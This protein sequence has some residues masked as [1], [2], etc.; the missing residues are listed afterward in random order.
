VRYVLIDT[1]CW[2]D[3][4]V[5]ETE[6]RNL[7][8]LEQWAQEKKII[9][10]VPE[11]LKEEWERNKNR[12]LNEIRKGLNVG[13]KGFRRKAQ[14]QVKLEIARVEAK[15]RRIDVIMSKGKFCRET[16]AVH[17]EVA[18]RRKRGIAPYHLN[19]DSD[20][21]A[22]IYFTTIRFCKSKKIEELIFIS[23][24]KHAYSVPGEDTALH[25]DLYVNEIEVIFQYGIGSGSNYLRQLLGANAFSKEQDVDFEPEFYNFDDKDTIPLPEKIYLALHAYHDQLPFIPTDLLVKVYPFKVAGGEPGYTYHSSFRINTNN[26]T[27]A[28]FFQSI[29]IRENDSIEFLKPELVKDVKNAKA[30]MQQVLVQLNRNLIFH[31]NAIRGSG[32]ADISLN[33]K[34]EQ[35]S[36]QD[37]FNNL[38]FLEAYV[39][40]EARP[41]KDLRKTTEQAYVFFQFGDFDTAIQLFDRVYEAA[42]QQGKVLLSFVALYNMKR[43]KSFVN[44]YYTSNDLRT[45]EIIKKVNNLPVRKHATAYDEEPVFVQ[46][47]IAWLGD[48]DFYHGAFINLSQTVEKIRNH[49]YLQLN[50]GFGTNSNYQNLVSEYLN[51]DQFLEINCI[52]FNSYS[53]FEEL[54]EKLAEGLFMMHSFSAKQSDRLDYLDYYLLQK[55]VLYAKRETLVKFYNRYGMRTIVKMDVDD[56]RTLLNMAKRFFGDYA[57]LRNVLLKTDE[58]N[59]FFFWEKYIKISGNLLLLLTI[60]ESEE[61]LSEVTRSIILVYTD[62]FMGKRMEADQI[63]DFIREK[64]KYINTGVLKNFLFVAINNP[65]FH[66]PQ[67]F[68]AFEVQRRRYH[69]DLAIRSNNVLEKIEQY[70]LRECPKC[71]TVHQPTLAAEI[72]SLLHE[73]LQAKMKKK[74][75]ERLSTK[76]NPELYY[77]FSMY[78]I[79]DFNYFFETFLESCPPLKNIKPRPQFWGGDSEANYPRLNEVINLAY[80]W[81]VATRER[82]YPRYK[83]ISL[84]YDWLM[85]SE[86][87]DYSKFD[88]EWILVYKT[89]TYFKKIFSSEKVRGFLSEWFKKSKHNVLAEL[90]AKYGMSTDGLKSG[91]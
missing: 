52:I 13:L 77:V 45:M 42:L 4:L 2:V 86:G 91:H 88:P 85:D 81:E 41:Q 8:D 65:N 56:R 53:N 7:F 72:Y 62:D 23:H 70:F 49:Y 55:M 48:T 30:K 16:N 21:D 63:A 75:K 17:V 51:L 59:P 11:R 80:K 76:F 22:Y 67:L 38:D 90:A 50:G 89:E 57:K 58:K 64:G 68:H 1:N 39:A 36:L 73:P 44:S 6:E 46:E 28:E 71:K 31:I 27:L 35:E 26:D 43:L 61:D 37:H 33:R 24:D 5:N 14:K 78:A 69:K 40:L 12:S 47:C 25:T 15:A 74:V 20:G 66:N 60:C 82:L 9:L 83:G 18:V 79:I 54:T 10:L 87:F 84:Y 3:L 32:E 19:A 34:G 29:E